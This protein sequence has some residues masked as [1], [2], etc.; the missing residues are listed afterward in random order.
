MHSEQSGWPELFLYDS[1]YFYSSRQ[2]FI[3]AKC[4]EP[5]TFVASHKRALVE[6]N[7]GPIHHVAAV[8]DHRYGGV[9]LTRPGLVFVSSLV[10]NNRAGLEPS[11]H[12]ELGSL[13]NTTSD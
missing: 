13:D 6:G 12:T 2:I 10:T 8:P 5:L 7:I 9:V 11:G 3:Q 4:Q 1:K